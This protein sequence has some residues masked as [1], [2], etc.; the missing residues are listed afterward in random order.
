[1]NHSK[2]DPEQ[3]KGARQV[4]ARWIRSLPSCARTVDGAKNNN[5][6]RDT[7]SSES[8]DSDAV[9]V[10]WQDTPS[11]GVF[12]LYNIT[13]KNHPLYKS[14]V[15]ARTLCEQKLKIPPTPLL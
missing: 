4:Y 3:V 2:R 13:L 11:G 14:T 6:Q 8:T 12:A 15:S 1:M 10:G 5:N 7:S 9:F